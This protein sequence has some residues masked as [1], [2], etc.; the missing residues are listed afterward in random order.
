MVLIK[1]N[2]SECDSTMMRG[3]LWGLFNYC[4]FFQMNEDDGFDPA[5]IPGDPR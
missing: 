4:P 3:L 1:G 2:R 5:N